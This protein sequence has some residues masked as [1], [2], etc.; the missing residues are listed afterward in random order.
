M[1]NEP[2]IDD[3]LYTHLT[4]ILSV[5]AGMVGVC[6]TAISLLGITKS[7]NKTETLIDDILAGD[8]VVFMV[9]ALLGFLGM[10]TRLAT[11]W[12]GFALVVDTIF[13]L[14]LIVTVIVAGLLASV[15]L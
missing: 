4:T 8:A 7:L 10:R 5:S 1:K 2:G 15:V 9:V 13:C 14:G 6:L 12:R 3:R 11:T